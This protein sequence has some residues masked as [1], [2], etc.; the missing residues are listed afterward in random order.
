MVRAGLVAV[1]SGIAT[2]AWADGLRLV[3]QDATAAARGEAF[4][5]TADNASAIYYNPAGITQLEG[6]NLRSGLY[7]IYLEPQFTPPANKPNHGEVYS[8]GK[9]F[10][11]V[12]DFFFTHRLKRTP[13]TVGLG[14][15]APYGGSVSWPDAAG[16]RSVAE[17]SRLTY[18]RV[19]PVVALKIS[20]QLSVAAGFNVDY[21]KLFLSQGILSSVNPQ[22]FFQFSGHGL[23]VGY[24]LGVL[25]HPWEKI[26]LGA[27][28]RGATSF[29]LSGQSEFGEGSFI[30]AQTRSAQM[31]FSFPLT[32]VLGASY[33]PNPNWNL[34][35][36]V[37]YTDWTSVNDLLLQQVPVTPLGVQ[38]NIP[39]KLE[40]QASWMFELGVTRQL[41]H[42][43]HV[44]AGYLFNQNSVPNKYY[45]PFAADLDRHFFNLGAGHHGKRWDWDV[46]YQL[47]YGPDHSV[48]GSSPSS[49]PG[50]FSTQTADGTYSFWSHAIFISGGLHF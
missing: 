18:L 23:S 3:S 43:W 7:G 12:P 33:R 38:Q 34:E 28:L 49:T 19:N 41:G 20:E 32:A 5:A 26:S 15:Y 17:A 29:T 50:F 9:H 27:T 39:V 6:N 1:A 30:P 16:F 47:G 10:A 40:W 37:D 44:S 45:T 21:A 35:F 14:I 11:G 8:V 31:D 4:T 25:W 13:F 2:V 24:N 22:N 36:D 42:G 48:S 46:T